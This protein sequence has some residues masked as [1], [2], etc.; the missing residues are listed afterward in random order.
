MNEKN[1]REIEIRH[2]DR[3]RTQSRAELHQ[4][5]IDE[6]AELMTSGV[7]FPEPIVYW[8]GEEYWLGDGFHRVA[9]AEKAGREKTECEIRTGGYL[10]ALKHSLQA[11]V[12]HGL[13]RTNDDKRHAVLIVLRQPEWHNLSNRG[14]AEMCGVSDMFVGKLRAET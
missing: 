2:I 10:D 13:R 3:R 1:I 9:A 14:I 8:E 6:Y 7:S 5:T 12:T 11:N 4:A